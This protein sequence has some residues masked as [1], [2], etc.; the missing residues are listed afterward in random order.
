MALRLNCPDLVKETTYYR[1]KGIGEG[2]LG[3]LRIYEYIANVR[4]LGGDGCQSGFCS[5]GLSSAARL[6]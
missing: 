5:C 6:S 2:P 4:G 1:R 3:T